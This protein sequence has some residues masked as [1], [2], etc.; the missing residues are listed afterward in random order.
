[1]TERPTPP[2]PITATLEPGVTWAVRNAAPTPVSTPQPSRHACSSRS[3]SVD[4]HEMV[5]ANEHVLGETAEADEL[6]HEPVVVAEAGRSVLRAE[7]LVCE[8]AVRIPGQ[9]LGAVTAVHRQAGDDVVTRAKVLNAVADRFHDAGGLVSQ[10][11]RRGVDHPDSVQ[12]VDV[13]VAHTACRDAH[14]DLADLRFVDVDVPHRRDAR[15]G[16]DDCSADGLAPSD[17]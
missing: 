16:V 14:Q 2:H 12:R 4:L 1:M 11:E 9:A 8:A 17:G 13:A 7:E 3:A 15:H 6:V 10:D 5:L